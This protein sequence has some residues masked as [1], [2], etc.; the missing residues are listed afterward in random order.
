MV[1]P[2]TGYLALALVW[3]TATPAMATII[4]GVEFTDLVSVDVPAG[5]NL[6]LTTSEDVYVFVPN[7]L[8]ADSIDLIV[9]LQI[10]IDAPISANTVSLCN[11]PIVCPMGEFDLQNDVLVTALDPVGSFRIEA[12]GSIILSTTPIPEPSTATLVV[13]GLFALASWR[14]AA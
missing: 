7:G 12:G 8:F 13:L 10:I 6:L 1:L 2:R 3:L 11:D 9:N 5:T 4:E 14:R